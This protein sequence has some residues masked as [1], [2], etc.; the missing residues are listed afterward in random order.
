MSEVPKETR[1]LAW[2][3]TQK[4]LRKFYQICESHRKGTYDVNKFTPSWVV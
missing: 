3:K 2:K 4:L 1:K